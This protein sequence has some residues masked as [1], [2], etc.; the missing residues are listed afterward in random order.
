MRE[1]AADK[2]FNAI[3]LTFVVL[4]LIMICYPLVYVLSASISDPNAVNAGRMWLWP[5]GVSLE[6][7]ERVFRDDEIWSG[8]LNTFIYTVLGTAVNLT[9]TVPCAYAL[10]KK[11]LPG[12]KIIMLLILFTMFFHGGIIP[13]YLVVK[14]LGMINTIW[15]LVIPQAA[16]VW[17]IIVTM[18]FFRNSVPQELEEAAA[19]D[20]S[21]VFRTFFS[22][23]LPLSAPILA[24]MGLF[25]GVGHWNQYFQALL[26]LSDEDLYPLQLVLRKILVMNQTSSLFM[27]TKDPLAMAE[28]A[29]I[30]ETIKYAVMIVSSLPLLIVYPFLQRYFV[31]GVLI[32]S[33]KS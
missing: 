12:V 21:T 10:S 23:V 3:N 31:K 22:I 17:N 13:S 5:V 11:N 14:Q 1:S 24:V 9:V 15:A 18:T 33:L 26:Y 19:I 32:G 27:D 4:L 25:Y 7:Y 20:G 16:A 2:I 29:R 28:Q 30:A 6:G 8:Y